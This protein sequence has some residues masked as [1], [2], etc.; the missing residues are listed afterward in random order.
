MKILVFAPHAALWQ[1]AFPQALVAESLARSG[2]Q[3]VYVSCAG[4][5]NRFCVPMS[6]SG[7]SPESSAQSRAVVCGEC[8][9]ND[10]LLRAALDFS[11]P[12]LRELVTHR[13]IEDVESETRSLDR[14]TAFGFEREGLP[15]GQIAIYQLLLRSKKSD[16]NLNDQEWNEY[17]VEIRNTA[18]SAIAAVRMIELHKP[19][20]LLVYNGLYSVNRAFSMAAENRGIPA[21]FMHAGGHLARRFQTVM[22]GRG[23][24]FRHM[25]AVLQQWT[26]FSGVPAEAANMS[27]VSEHFLELL[28]GQNIY[29]YSKGRSRKP[30]DARKHFGLSPD[31]KLIVATMSSNDEEAAGIIVGA[32]KPRENMLF[33]TQ[34]EWVQA[35]LQF[36]SARPDLFLVIRVHP[37]EFPNRREG[38]KSQHAHLLESAL[39]DLPGNAAVNWPDQNI[40]LYDLVDQ[41]DVFLNAWSSVGR[42]MPM[43]GIPVVI[44]SAQMQW[45]PANINYLGESLDSYFKAID[46]A[47]ADG[48]SLENAR[49]AYRWSVYEFFTS[50]IPIGDSYPAVEHSDRGL[51]TK[52]IDRLRRKIDPDYSKRNDVR[53]RRAKLGAAS[54]IS[55][56][57][58]TADA[59]IMDRMRPEHANANTL[60]RESRAL[61]LELRRLAAVLFPDPSLRLGNR[62]FDLM[63]GPELSSLGDVV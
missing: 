21:Y 54:Q 12:T 44:Y 29:V 61:K 59:T 55:D 39:A 48:W 34:I 4:T 52:A 57:L 2:H 26:K 46:Q 11:G 27:L 24:T 60:E 58:Q 18:Y 40:S 41:T 15:V 10:S 38:R 37:R 13:D 31:Q 6:A 63:H 23:E 22:L 42:E 30:F 43:L 45:Y 53:R 8:N 3:I 9:R 20:R 17:L 50:T 32:Q 5:L 47:L 19:D 35:L 33:E 28:K 49:R 1:L 14:E 62:L 56:L 25:A 7:L 16:L 51:K 36:I